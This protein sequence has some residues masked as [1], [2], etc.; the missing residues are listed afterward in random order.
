VLDGTADAAAI[1][2][3]VLLFELRR[4]P[5]LAARL[6]TIASLGPHG[7]QPVLV[8]SGAAAARKLSL[9]RFFEGLGGD[10]VLRPILAERFLIEGFAPVG[11]ADYDRERALLRK[12]SAAVEPSLERG[13]E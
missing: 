13:R 11:D 4:R 10:P 1:D 6:R 3:N 5:G 7:V 2:S 12:A 9:R 8:R